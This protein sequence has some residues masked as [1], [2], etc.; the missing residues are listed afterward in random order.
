MPAAATRNPRSRSHTSLDRRW[1]NICACPWK[2]M[3]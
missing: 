3:E 2:R 1:R